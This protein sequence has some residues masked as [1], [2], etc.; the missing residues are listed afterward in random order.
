[1]NLLYISSNAQG[2][3]SFSK[4]DE[5]FDLGGRLM[6]QTVRYF[7]PSLAKTIEEMR[8]DARKITFCA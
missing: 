2:T 8:S 3:R 1:M 4:I 5:A 6:A 7:I